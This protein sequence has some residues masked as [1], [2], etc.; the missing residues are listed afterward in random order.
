MNASAPLVDA[1]LVHAI[2]RARECLATELGDRHVNRLQR[3]GPRC[4]RRRSL[5]EAAR[6]E[7]LEHVEQETIGDRI[8]WIDRL[9]CLHQLLAVAFTARDRGKRLSFGARQAARRIWKLLEVALDR[10]AEE[11]HRLDALDQKRQRAR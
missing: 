3:V 5:D 2:D 4:A 6:A 10:A 11:R 9:R 1:L 8:A 7:A